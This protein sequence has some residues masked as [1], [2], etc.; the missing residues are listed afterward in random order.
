MGESDVG[1]VIG[2]DLGTTYSVVAHIAS[3]GRP[4]VIPN[5]FGHA[6]T[7]SVISFGGGAPVVGEDAKEQQAAGSEQVASFF[8]RD[9]GDPYFLLSFGGRD[10]TPAD[11]SALVLAH[12]K[13]QAER[14]L[15]TS[16]T[17]AVIT[18][19]AYFTHTQRN[20]TI[21]AGRQ[22][23]LDV[24]TIISEPTAAALA[25]GLRPL[26]RE[27][28]ILVYDLGG[29][30]FDVSLVSI[31][32]DALTVVGTG[33][34]HRLGGR[35]W[36]DR[37]ALLLSEQFEHQFGV[38]L[39]GDQVN[40]LLVQAEKLKHTLSAR[41]AA[42]TR[43]QAGEHSATYTVTRAQFE[44]A[45][46]D[47]LVR[48][49]QLCGDVLREAGWAW[50]R[51][52]GVIPVGGSTRMP[53]VRALIERMSGKAP[54]GGVNP[55]EAVALGAAL[56]AAME[57]ERRNDAPMYFLPGRKRTQD[58]IAHSLG[59]IAE[60]AN[61]SR[62]I[63]SP[64]IRK[65]SQIPCAKTRPFEINVR[66]DGGNT[67]DVF[68]TQG[69]TDDPQDCVYLGRYIFSNFPRL[70]SATATL[71]ITYEYDQSGLVHVSAIERSTGTPLTLTVES[72]PDDVPAR[73]MERPGDIRAY[74]P[75][76]LYLAF[77]LSGSMRG[78]PLYEAKKA[79]RAFVSNCNLE[80]T[81]VGLISFSDTVAVD[82][83]ATRNNGAIMA[84]IDQLAIG[85]TGRGNLAHPFNE[86]F[87]HLQP[88]AGNK[89][90]IVL[91]DGVWVGQRRAVT[92]ARRCHAVGIQIIA[93]GFGKA[94]REFLRKIASS[95]EQSFFTDLSRLTETFSTIA[96]E[97]AESPA[98]R[99]GG[100]VRDVR[101]NG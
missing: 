88:V 38:E 11:L 83:R 15:G 64:L 34:D 85:K 59:L 23:G 17:D 100:R 12:L 101:W 62:Y 76:T 31:T 25:Y 68:L 92:A 94:D 75:M 70:A 84:A 49:E 18:V 27:Q 71:D 39:I 37:L 4:E 3:D 47:L 67:L 65:N 89:Y 51:V 91:A 32:A 7:P 93:V 58:V 81:S 50:T 43:V 46:R 78:V 61:R 28:H 21:E 74:E 80:T 79:A 13:A 57:V 87:D 42:S 90:A 73:F 2:I 20:A 45:C 55:D 66:R 86:I 96:R 97:L 16:V 63:N 77:D 98:G 30:T 10:Y 48:T 26:Q 56:Q 5:E 60:S 35:D 24:L 22:A 53:M 72:V 69:E 99:A 52:D 41:E 44:D 14:H 54:L 8:K 95:D 36:D 29:G 40:A 82:Q 19:P 1:G 9:M 33:G 6:T